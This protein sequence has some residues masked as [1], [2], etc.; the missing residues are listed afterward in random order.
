VTILVKEEEKDTNLNVDIAA[1]VLDTGVLL[2]SERLLVRVPIEE[3]EPRDTT[4]VN[5][6]EI[7]CGAEMEI[8][9]ATAVDIA[10]KLGDNK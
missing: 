3:L 4:D 6:L 2:T 1:G 10:L 8:E 7:V 5:W 9:C